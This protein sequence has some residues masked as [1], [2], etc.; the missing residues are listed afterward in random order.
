MADN[1]KGRD[2]QADDQERRQRE[3]ELT[4]ARDRAGEVEPPLNHPD[5]ELG[6]LNAALETI[7][8]PTTTDELIEVYGD[9]TV[10]SQRGSTAIRNVLALI[11]N[12]TYD[13]ADE[14]RTR[15]LKLL[16]R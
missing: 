6:D 12:E 1:K 4:E 15:M 5:H 2:K 3:R 7:H 13:S 14:V 8:Y 10:H 16:H 11:D 9:R